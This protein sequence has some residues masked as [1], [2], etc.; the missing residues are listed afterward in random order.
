MPSHANPVNWFEIPVSDLSRAKTFYETILA[1]EITESEM[2]P[3]KMGW[4]PM[5]MGASGSAGTLIKGKRTV[6]CILQGAL[7]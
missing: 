4:F 7:C 1:L 3:N 5:E 2:G 6:K